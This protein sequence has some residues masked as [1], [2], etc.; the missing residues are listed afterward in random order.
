MQRARAYQN[1]F[2]ESAAVVAWPTYRV[3]LLLVVPHVNVGMEQ[4]VVHGYSAL[5]IDDEHLGEQVAGLARLQLVVLV[6]VGGEEHVREELLEAE[7]RVAGPVLHV[8]AHGGLQPHH[9]LGRGRA[10]LFC[11]KKCSFV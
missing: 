10:Q 1:I 2:Y 5:R 6:A 7:A 8:V 3:H 11:G 9:E 4:G